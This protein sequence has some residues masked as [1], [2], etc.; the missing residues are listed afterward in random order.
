MSSESPHNHETPVMPINKLTA[1]LEHSPELY[2]GRIKELQCMDGRIN[3]GYGLAGS[4]IL[5][6]RNPNKPDLPD[7]IYIENMEEKRDKREIKE[8]C[9]HRGCGAAKLYLNSKGNKNPTPEEV[10]AAAKNFAEKLAAALG[11]SPAKESKH[12][13]SDHSEK[14]IYVDATDKLNTRSEALPNGFLLSPN[15]PNN[16]DYNLKEIEVAISISFGGHGPGPDSFSQEKP[17]FIMLICDE[18]RPDYFKDFAK[19]IQEMID[20]NKQFAQFA[21][22]IAIKTVTPSLNK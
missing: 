10:D 8:I 3:G 9:W 12:E 14:G 13:M 4:G 15:I 11:L 19:K 17:Y 6:K 2:K 18:E 1:L 22:K 20:N 16:L 21:N 5:L 7:P